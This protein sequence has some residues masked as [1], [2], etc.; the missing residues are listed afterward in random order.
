MRRKVGEL[1][2]RSSVRGPP[3]LTT[4]QPG[5]TATWYPVPGSVCATHPGGTTAACVVGVTVVDGPVVVGVSVVGGSVATVDATACDRSP[6]GSPL[7]VTATANDTSASTTDPPAINSTR[8]TNGS[9]VF[10]ATRD[11]A[12]WPTLDP[13]AAQPPAPW[14]W[15]QPQFPSKPGLWKLFGPHSRGALASIGWGEPA[16]GWRR[17]RIW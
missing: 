9:I 12:P 8:R 13:P 5:G 15:P 14:P 4:C 2:S 3:S 7:T 16:R 6:S 17:W 11:P 1:W 10:R